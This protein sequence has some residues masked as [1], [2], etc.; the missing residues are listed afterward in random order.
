M[1]L[2]EMKSLSSITAWS[3]ER[4]FTMTR[5]NTV[6]VLFASALIVMVGFGSVGPLAQLSPPT[7]ETSPSQAEGTAPPVETPTAELPASSETI[8]ERGVKGTFSPQ[9]GNMKLLLPPPTFAVVSYGGKCLDFGPPPQ[10]T[11]A[12]VFI[13][14]C[15]G[16]V[17]Q[18]VVVQE[19]N[20]RHDVILR[21]GTKVLGVK[22]GN[23]APSVLSRGIDSMGFALLQAQ[24]F[25]T[26][27]QLPPLE[28]QDEQSRQ[29]VLSSGAGQI[30]ALDGD[31]IMLAA[32]RT[33]VVQVQNNRGA[34]RTP[35]VL[36]PRNL[37]DAEFWTFAATD[38]S[39]R[40]PT[41]GFVRVPQEKDFARAVNEAR[42]GTVVEVDPG[43]SLALTT[44]LPLSVPEGVTIR[45]DRRGLRFGPEL[46]VPQ[47][48]EGT[49]LDIRF[50]DVRVTGLRLRGPSRS[51]V[52]EAS[53]KDARAIDVL[54]SATRVLIDH[55]DISDWPAQGV[56]VVMADEP[57]VCN[58][59]RDPRGARPNNVRVTRNFIHHNQKQNRGYGVQAH[60]NS[61]PLIDGNTFVSNRHAIEASGTGC[62]NY[63]AWNNLVL[64]AAPLQD[65]AGPFNGYTHDFDVHGT[66]RLKLDVGFDIDLTGGFGGAAGQ[67]F[68]IARNTFLG[69][70]RQNF[71]LRGEPSSMVEFH[72]NISLRSLGDAVACSYCGNGIK[73]LKVYDTNRFSVL[74]NPT[75]QLGVGDFDGDERDDLFLAT[76][77]AWY[78]APAGN[79]DWRF[80]NAQTDKIDTLLFGDFDGDRR[81]DV[82]TQRGRDWLV[83]WAGASP[84]EKIN[85]SNPALSE[86]RIGDFIGDQRADV[87]YADGQRWYVSDGGVGPFV[88]T[89][90]SSFRAASLGFGD[91]N[92][93][94]KTDVVGS[95][96]GKWMVS[97]N[98]SGPWTGYPLRSALTK[99]MAGMIIADFNGNGRADIAQAYGKSVSYDGRGGWTNMP[100]RPGMFAAVGRFDTNPG[101]DILFY[102]TGYNYL[103]IQ[104]SGVGAPQ[105]QSRQD[106]R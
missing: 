77:A 19:I 91:F 74:P 44:P 104:S 2:A 40:K 43:V 12:P 66:E 88:H 38:K 68:E 25:T 1:T 11:G 95:T 5:A 23:S 71:D 45:G 32:D 62:T 7:S 57:A 85:E 51:T 83:S 46:S 80:L 4:S 15:N 96:S 69:T 92:G 24:P 67:Y 33:R 56:R 55:N 75:A 41:S 105:R 22:G 76:G 37:A 6:V 29:T 94:G 81:I 97:L 106:M 102:W 58:D 61:F 13:Y 52:D 49:M 34:N 14:P 64:A 8:Q 48:F 47:G 101:A 17:A 16:T 10:V 93:D 28:L 39:A 26:L 103:G 90:D 35:L 73:K 27:T 21:A 3:G 53:N 31:S 72:H 42:W 84:W 18:Q 59:H 98:A 50:S 20:D 30:F 65:R 99:T 63:L 79:A 78:Y 100:A 60:I 86:F 87:F 9:L 54:D 82:F 70:N 36:G 89:Q